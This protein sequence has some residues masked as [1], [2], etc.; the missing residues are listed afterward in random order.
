MK[1]LCFLLSMVALGV[2]LAAW[3]LHGLTEAIFIFLGGIALWI[4]TIVA[5]AIGAGAAETIA[6]AYR[7]FRGKKSNES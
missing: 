3:I 6:I 1:F 4:M 2:F 7:N 5:Y